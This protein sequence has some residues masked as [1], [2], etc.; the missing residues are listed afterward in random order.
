MSARYIAL[1]NP[2]NRKNA[3]NPAETASP[4]RST[5]YRIK[6]MKAQEGAQRRARR[7]RRSPLDL[8]CPHRARLKHLNTA[9]EGG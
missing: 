4:Y 1:A 5:G 9:V 8:G 3:Q 7:A 6:L 2:S